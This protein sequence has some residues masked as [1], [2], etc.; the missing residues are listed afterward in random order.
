[1]NFV[2][3]TSINQIYEENL[4]YYVAVKWLECACTAAMVFDIKS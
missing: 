3:D 4:S 1:M 2:I